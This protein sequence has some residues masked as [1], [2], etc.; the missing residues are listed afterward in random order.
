M[1]ASRPSLPVR[2]EYVEAALVSSAA[3]WSWS[4][5]AE[6]DDDPHDRDL[7]SMCARLYGK[8][9]TQNR[10]KRALAPPPKSRRLPDG[11]IEIP[12]GWMVQ[13]FRFTLD[14][15][16]ERPARWARH[17]A[18]R[19]A[20]NWTVATLSRYRRLRLGSRRQSRR[21]GC[22]GSAGTPSRT[23]CAS[24]SRPGVWWPECSKEAYADGIDGAVRR[25]PNRQNSRS[26][27]VMAKGW[28]FPVC[29]D[30]TQT[31]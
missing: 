13:A 3:S 4:T 29:K 30:A 21:C 20:Y 9:A 28:A 25:V 31:G 27:N 1:V 11:E 23:T 8:R 17:F 24:T 5:S 12:E 2:S 6:V 19:K 18:R 16:A 15:T 22:C 14:P 10:A 7:D 26:E